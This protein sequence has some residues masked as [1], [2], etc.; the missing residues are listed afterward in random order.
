MRIPILLIALVV[1]TT[2]A[3]GEGAPAATTV[4]AMT[5]AITGYAHAGPTCPVLQ[6]P[7]DPACADRPVQDAGVLVLAADGTVV[8]RTVTQAD[9]SFTVD[10]PAGSYTVVF[11][12]VQGLIG[13]AV[14]QEVVVVDGP[15]TG[16]DGA[17][18]TGIR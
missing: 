4:P 9:G 10:V 18:D 17:Y 3:C 2:A 8:A 6:D 7:P 11:Q 13:T 1:A 16:V 14:P 15:V 12:P 5:F